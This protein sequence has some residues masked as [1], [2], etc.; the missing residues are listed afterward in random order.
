[1]SLWGPG[2]LLVVGLLL[3]V[4]RAVLLAARRAPG[5]SS[6]LGASAGLALILATQIPASSGAVTTALLG[7]VG[8]TAIAGFALAARLKREHALRVAEDDERQVALLTRD[9]RAYRL[10]LRVRGRPRRQG[11]GFGGPLDGTT[12]EVSAI[13]TFGSRPP[14]KGVG[15][16]PPLASRPLMGPVRGGR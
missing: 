8:L 9:L 7:W 3:T 5:A 15:R 2:G 14:G 6:W 10:S 1:M 13:P 4:G 16:A 12:R 11:A